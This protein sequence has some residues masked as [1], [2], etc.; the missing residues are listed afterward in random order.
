MIIPE[1]FVT[2][3]TSQN[4]SVASAGTSLY[5][6]VVTYSDRIL[7]AF[8]KNSVGIMRLDQFFSA[9]HRSLL[10]TFSN[11]W[12][13]PVLRNLHISRGLACKISARMGFQA[14][15]GDELGSMY[16]MMGVPVLNQLVNGLAFP[17]FQ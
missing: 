10:A 1:V 9:R 15:N 12:V 13:G 3:G 5:L 2:S 16:F 8:G 11:C 17:I 6:Q 7:P 4:P 14:T